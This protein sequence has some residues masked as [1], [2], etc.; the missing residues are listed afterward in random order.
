MLLHIELEMFLTNAPDNIYSVRIVLRNEFSTVCCNSSST[1][2]FLSWGGGLKGYIQ[3]PVLEV[4]CE[5]A[6]QHAGLLGKAAMGNDTIIY[7][8]SKADDKVNLI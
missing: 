5:Y 1:C 2:Q 3:W 6:T 7:V 8:R 4:V